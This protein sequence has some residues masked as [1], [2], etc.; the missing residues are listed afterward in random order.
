[1]HYGKCGSG[2]FLPFSV[3]FFFSSSSF[4]IS[5]KA[6]SNSNLIWSNGRTPVTFLQVLGVSSVKGSVT[7]TCKTDA[8]YI[9]MLDGLCASSHRC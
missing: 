1:M 4:P 9:V 7:V 3:R 2:V 5:S 6:D 8:F